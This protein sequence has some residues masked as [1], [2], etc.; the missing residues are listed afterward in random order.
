MILVEPQV[1]VGVDEHERTHDLSLSNGRETRGF[2]VRGGL[3]KLGQGSRTPTTILIKGGRGDQWGDHD[4]DYAHIQQS[5]WVGGMMQEEFSDD[6][7]RYF[8][9]RNVFSMVPGRMIPAYRYLWSEGDYRD[10]N[11]NPV[12]GNFNW[13]AISNNAWGKNVAQT[14]TAVA[15]DTIS[16]DAEA[17]Y[18]WIRMIGTPGDLI[19]ALYTDG[20]GDPSVLLQSVTISYTDVADTPA[21][22]YKFDIATQTLTHNTAY[23][24][25][26][27]SAGDSENHWEIGVDPDGTSMQY[28]DDGST[29]T[30]PG[31][32]DLYYRVVDADAPARWHFFSLGTDE[33]Y[34]VAEYDSGDSKLYQWDETND[35]W[36]YVSS[37][38]GDALSGT[39]KDVAVSNA[40]AHFARGSA[41]GDETIFTFYEGDSGFY[42]QDD[43]TAGNKADKILAARDAMDGP[44]IWRAENETW[45]LSRG[46]VEDFNTDISFGDDIQL[47]KDLDV[48]AL[49]FY[50]DQLYARTVDGVWSVKNDVPV[51]LGVGFGT[52]FETASY[53]PMLDKDLFLFIAWDYTL[54]RLYGSTLDDIGPW[55]NAGLPEDYQ[56]V[57]ADLCSGIGMTFVAIDGGSANYSSV[58]A[59]D[60]QNYHPMF[61][62]PE[63]GQRIRSVAWQPVSGA[64]GR[65]WISYGGDS[66]YITF[67][68]R[69]L[70]PLHDSNMNYHHEGVWES[71]TYTMNAERLKKFFSKLDFIT[72]RLGNSANISVEYKCDQDIGDSTAPWMPVTDL[73]DSPLSEASLHLGNK[74][75]IRFR[76]IMRT[77]DSDKPCTIIATILDC[78]ARTPIKDIW[79]LRV[80]IGGKTKIN[81]DDHNPVDLYDWLKDQCK[82]AEVLKM[83]ANDPL[84]D[85]RYVIIEPPNLVR[86][87]VERLRKWFTGYAT[88]ILKEA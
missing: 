57:V 73:Y 68:Q 29:W 58:L 28:S 32:E 40:L 61:T 74:H 18:L 30:S 25:V 64:A 83:R 78:F 54:E 69:T 75:R 38:N 72:E 37:Y 23:H 5:T 11:H 46:N 14:F 70:N 77:W 48:L 88:F 81:E 60:G 7:T 22:W 41:S 16:Y 39:V 47:P 79:E 43:T 50:N 42:G 65:L 26:L 1:R 6:P 31:T 62:G 15:Q 59:F 27:Y 33:F 2:L 10:Y 13:Y 85:D 84:M 4:P 45:V 55:R 21:V 9:G 20:A 56:G 87:S 52:V 53:V 19:V 63:K 51:K 76:V 12:D 3:E 82:N 71:S 35:E 36:D 49:V 34:K 80:N 24:V 67:P 17:I 8:Y 44:Q 86:K 66:I